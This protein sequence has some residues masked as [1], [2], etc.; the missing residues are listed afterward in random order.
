MDDQALAQMVE[1]AADDLLGGQ[2]ARTITRVRAVHALSVL[3]QRIATDAANA[4]LLS[5]LTTD[6][7]A[8]RLNVSARRVRALA[9]ARNVGWQVSRGT[10]IFRPDDIEKL[11]PYTAGRPRKS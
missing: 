8:A 10:W 3:A 11:R 5:L 4:A 1:S 9:R 7:M 2:E 6:D